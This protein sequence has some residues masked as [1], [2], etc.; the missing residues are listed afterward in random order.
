MSASTSTAYATPRREPRP[1]RCPRCDERPATIFRTRH[2][3]AVE[4]A[5]RDAFFARRI[6]RPRSR[7]ELRD[8][9]NVVLG[10]PADILRCAAC[11]ILIRDEAPDD[12][13]FRN[14]RYD[15][16]VL[17]SLHAVHAA[18]FREKEPDY[19]ELLHHGARVAEIGSYVGGFLATA[20]QWGWSAIGVDIGIDTSRF[21]RALGFDVV[22]LSLETSRFARQSFDAV[23][24]WN[25]FEQLAAPRLTLAET[26][27]ILR[28][29]GLLV[30]RVPD[31]DFYGRF[32]SVA[33]RAYN[34][35]LG[36]PHRFGFGAS[37]LRR[38]AA[39][40]GFAF[41]RLLRA[42]AIRPLR[43]A[44]RTFAR[45]EES[46]LFADRVFGWIEMTFR[47]Q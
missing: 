2:E 41:Q 29:S 1:L 24:I 46:A 7:N 35:L 37:E 17:E 31:A 44:L 27:R 45:D 16:A 47:K 20:R 23:F 18:A 13:V 39:D 4:L 34:N 9:T 6:D 8:L 43:N 28:R 32:Q 25:C 40:R 30:I 14:D 5:M 10:T 26:Y 33:A 22:S 15:E 12:E 21:S 11:G 3:I 36:W 38:F 19:R 42:P